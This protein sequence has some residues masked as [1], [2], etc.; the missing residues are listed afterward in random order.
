MSVT[1]IERTDTEILTPFKLFV[2]Q[3]FPFIEEDFDSLTNYQI[4][5]KMV[6]YM[7]TISS[8]LNILSE[9]DIKVFEAFNTVVDYINDYFDNLDVQE[10]I[11]NKLDDL[12]NDGTLTNL[13]STYLT[14][15]IEE[16][17]NVINNF[18]NQVESNVALLSTRVNS[19]LNT[20]PLAVSNISGMT[21]TSKTYVLTTDGNW[22][23]YNG[24]NWVIGGVYQA[25]SI[26][27]NSVGYKNLTTMVKKKYILKYLNADSIVWNKGYSRYNGNLTTD[28]TVTTSQALKFSKGSVINCLSEELLVRYTLYD[29]N[30][31]YIRNTGTFR[32]I[33]TYSLDDDYYVV[34]SISGDIEEATSTNIEFSAINDNIFDVNF[35]FY[36]SYTNKFLSDVFYVG[37]GTKIK[38]SDYGLKNSG[39]NISDSIAYIGYKKVNID[40]ITSEYVNFGSDNVYSNQEIEVPESMYLQVGIRLKG[41]K[42]LTDAQVSNLTN[43]IIIDYKIDNANSFID[44]SLYRTYIS[45]NGKMEF[46]PYTS[47]GL[48]FRIIGNHS[49]NIKKNET[50][51]ISKTFASLLEDFP[52]KTVEYNGNNY[53]LLNQY[54]S[55][56]Y[57]LNY[58]EFRIWNLNDSAVGNNIINLVCNAYGQIID[59]E[60]LRLYLKEINGAENIF[61]SANWLSQI[62]WKTKCSEYTSHFNITSKNIESFVFFTDQHL[63][64][65]SG[66]DFSSNLE[67]YIGTLQKVYNSIPANFIVSGGDWL[68]NGDTPENA[69]FKLG[70]IDGFMNSMF[71][72]YYGIVGNHDTNYQ[73]TERLTQTAIDNVWYRKTKKAYY[74]FEGIN[75]MNYCFDSGTDSDNVMRDYRWEQI[76]WFAQE[77][78]TDNPT[79]ATVFTHIIWNNDVVQNFADN[80]TKL[81]NAFNTH[82]SITLNSITYDFTNTTG[83]IDYVLSGHIHSD[84]NDTVNGVLCIATT[85][86]AYSQSTPTFDMV[87]N[88][89]DN[90]KVYLTRFG[91]GESR[92]FDI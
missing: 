82:T 3:N 88:D 62:N 54:R 68:N 79:H 18:K 31:N 90:N 57:D 42:T 63:M 60:L 5:S 91:N 24:T 75:S 33:P 52:S 12:V 29:M 38:F 81:I 39:G 16:Q 72:N 50:T 30:G 13:I 76:N 35:N 86:F 45:D 74:K 6:E 51:L 47:G 73:G 55:L 78:L 87:F 26:G 48:L 83:H 77:L 37:K 65:Y 28:A 34:I 67:T 22:Y 17:N 1:H 7:N 10:E 58:N 36:G 44:G 59:C 49:I 32:N 61:N 85:T 2:L 89:Y 4:M 92:V 23:Y 53:L 70:Y 20:P 9:N 19:A 15:Y 41:N 14:P 66:T 8:N 43:S 46:I 71:K 27:E 84:K 69:C 21:D 64:G 40:R 56:F 11:N 80:L 25:T